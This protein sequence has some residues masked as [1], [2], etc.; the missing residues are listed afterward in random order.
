M[1]FLLGWVWGKRFV[2][3]KGSG[4]DA[5]HLLRTV[6]R[7]ALSATMTGLAGSSKVT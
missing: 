6:L 7:P 4:L 2:A 5:D 1:I 3:L